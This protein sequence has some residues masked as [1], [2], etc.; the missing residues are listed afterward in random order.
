MKRKLAM[1]LL[2]YSKEVNGAFLL[3]GILWKLEKWSQP[4]EVFHG[5]RG[6]K[7][8]QLSGSLPW[9]MVTDEE[10]PTGKERHH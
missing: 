5:A 8:G 10:E 2:S 1:C 6:A 7:S 4:A 3:A 9:N